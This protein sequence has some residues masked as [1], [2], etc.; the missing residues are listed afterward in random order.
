MAMAKSSFAVELTFKVN[1]G[2]A[3]QSICFASELI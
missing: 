2:K 1:F 3:S